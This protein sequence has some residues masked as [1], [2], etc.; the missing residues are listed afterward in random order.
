MTSAVGE[1]AAR[2]T[3]ATAEPGEAH[4]FAARIRSSRAVAAVL[5]AAAFLAVALTAGDPGVTWDEPAY[6]SSARLELAWLGG[7]PAH[8]V[9]G[10]LPSWTSAETLAAHW[11][12]NP[13]NNPHPPFYKV[14]AGLGWALFHPLLGDYPAFRLSSAALFALVVAVLALWGVHAAGSRAAGVGAALA[15]ALMPRAV[16]DAH[17]AA[18]DMPLTA[19]W[20]LAAWFFWRAARSPAR[21]HVLLFG[22]CWGMALAT[23]FNGFLL[24]APLVLW[25]LLHARREVPRLL[26]VGGVV[27]LGL[28]VLLNPHLWPD[29]LGRTLA[30][31]QKSTSREEWAPIWTYYMGRVHPFVLPWHHAS[32]LTL[33]TL[34]LPLLVLAGAGALRIRERR[35]RPLVLL[36]LVQVVFHQA[37]MALP[38]SPGHDGVRLFLPQFPFLALLAGLGFGRLWELVRA[39]AGEGRA[40]LAR[41]ALVAVFFAPPLA[42]VAHS[43]PVQLAYYN[44]VVGGA[45]GAHARG[46]ESTYWFDAATP[47]FLRRIERELPRGAR[48]WAHPAPSQWTELQR[49]GLLRA[50]LVFT[51]VL[52]APY[53]LLL[54][55]QGIFSPF[56]WRLHRA[57]RPLVSRDLDG[58]T[59]IAL[60]AWE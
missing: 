57:V 17:V 9:D 60:Y 48:V 45:A 33:I 49:A 20:T 37:L 22:A 56:E 59:L 50:D 47:E 6:L 8:A 53:L 23:K 3:S 31:I 1:V 43:H 42:A 2:A 40:A 15:W 36:C 12:V 52:P 34:P 51:D 27:A 54:T 5:G 32:V 16:G 4:G 30:F 7:V 14:L 24:P 44:E 28:M 41:A 10:S 55:R 25:G 21:H 26:I 18:T 38:A 11:N 46:F 19:F 39:R 35:L 58:V 29:P 13:Y